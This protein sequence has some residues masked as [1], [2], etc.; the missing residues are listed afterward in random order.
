MNVGS[1]L[2][3][4]Y[5][6][7]ALIG[8]GGMGSVWRAEHLGLRAAVA[9]KLMDPSLSD[10]REAL[11]RFLREA[12]SAAALR[13]PHVVQ[14]L[15]HGVDEPTGVP[16][17]AMELMEGESL[18]Q[19]LERVRRLSAAE[20]ARVLSHVARALMRAHEAGIVHRDLKPDNIFI[21]RNEDE[22][23]AK[24]LDFGIAKA[25]INSL[26]GSSSTR[27]G[28]VLGTPYY[29]SPEQISGS[30]Q[31]DFGT[32]LWALGVIAFECLTGRR[33]FEADTIGGLAIQICTG[34]PSSPSSMGPVPR[35]FDAWFA[36]ATARKPADRFGSARDMAED[37]RRV[38]GSASL[39]LGTSDARPS[40][41]TSTVDAR[42]FAVVSVTPALPVAPVVPVNQGAARRRY[43][44]PIAGGVG[45]AAVG[46]AVWFS[47]AGSP[48][49]D[50]QA[51]EARALTATAAGAA[52]SESSA[53]SAAAPSVDN[54]PAPELTPVLSPPP[55]SSAPPSAVPV[56]STKPRVKSIAGP[57]SAPARRP[58]KPPAATP[59]EGAGYG[60]LDDR[61]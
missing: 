38:C 19:R 44:A 5:R 14:I 34:E 49:V 56:S 23:I 36:R 33:P 35:G 25:D 47:T 4:R 32:D 31:I 22:E 16:F 13:S 30:K 18:A 55:T 57:V 24:V 29:M 20:T 46:A 6:L 12:Q 10:S 61:R 52:A 9:I 41:S 26:G 42:S 8:R 39:P 17:I 21:V 43:W 15:D 45:L 27:T 3:G 50:P 58:A 7:V 51:S 11:D 1:I 37:L 60:V 48:P 54:P 59:P 28:S 2:A 53:T 40:V